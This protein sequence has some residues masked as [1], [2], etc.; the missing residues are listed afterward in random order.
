MPEEIYPG[1]F[2]II[3]PLPESP[4]KYLNSY[5]IRGEGRNLLIDTGLNREECRKAML[6][7]LCRLKIDLSTI[8]IFI[9]HL[10]ADHFGLLTKIAG[11]DTI[12]YFNRP[13]SEIIEN[14]QGFEPMIRMRP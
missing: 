13:D 9:T 1:L 5:L 7:G 3:I 10:H 6:D 4:L 11:P 2:R 12:V 14:W 8:E